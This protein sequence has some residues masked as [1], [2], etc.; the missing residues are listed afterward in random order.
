VP[1]LQ[2]HPRPENSYA[3][4]SAGALALPGFAQCQGIAQ[5]PIV[6]AATSQL[7][8]KVTPVAPTGEAMLHDVTCVA[9]HLQA[10][11]YFS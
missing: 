6:L 7:F 11:D 4:A 9:F 3:T 8:N 5:I 10:M 2:D 1:N